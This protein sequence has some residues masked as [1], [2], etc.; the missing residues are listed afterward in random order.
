MNATHWQRYY[1]LLCFFT[2]KKDYWAKHFP[3]WRTAKPPCFLQSSY[4][5]GRI[6]TDFTGWHSATCCIFESEKSWTRASGRVTT[7][8]LNSGQSD[9]LIQVFLI[10]SSTKPHA[11]NSY[12]LKIVELCLWQKSKDRAA[13]NSI[14]HVHCVMQNCRKK[15]ERG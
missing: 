9:F 4:T 14:V 5:S 13:F 11:F 7:H 10:L 3:C 12:T 1:Y 8:S 2:L 15:K 6:S